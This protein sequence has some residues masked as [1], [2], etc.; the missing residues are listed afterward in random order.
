VVPVEATSGFGA[1]EVEIRTAV[2]AGDNV[3][4]RGRERRAQDELLTAGRRLTA[5]DIG[6][7]ALVGASSVRV[8]RRPRVAVL[9]TGN[10]LVPHSTT[11][12]AVHIRNSNGP[13]LGSLALPWAP[14]VQQLG[15]ACASESDNEAR[16]RSGLD[17]DVLLVSGGVSMGEYD[18]V[19]AAL[20]RLG[21]R[22]HF[23]R[24]ALQPGKPTTF[25]THAGGAVL[26]L[27]GNPVSAL[28][29]FRLFAIQ[30]CR[31]LEGED[32]PRPSF[33]VA[34]AAF[35]WQRRHAKWL[36]LPARRT[37]VGVELVPYAGSGDLLAY[38]RADCQVVLESGVLQVQ[39]GDAIRVWS[40]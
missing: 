21:V 1:G 20:R 7:L 39:P 18:F 30:A 13:M 36:V 15:V 8:G 6:A 34:P 2:Q 9:S 37:P 28:V 16:L 14:D 24:V 12:D 22:L 17:C 40:L 32:Q 38:A 10:E 4:R 23:D 5:A 26:A 19:A 35:T 25:G 29:T 3:T 27:P 31:R 33:E 11:P